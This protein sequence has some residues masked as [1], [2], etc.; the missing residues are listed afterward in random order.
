MMD[1]PNH[2]NGMFSFR[3]NLRMRMLF[4][5]P[6]AFSTVPAGFSHPLHEMQPSPPCISANSFS[7]SGNNTYRNNRTGEVT[8]GSTA[9]RSTMLPHSSWDAAA[10]LNPKSFNAV[11]TQRSASPAQ[12]SSNG[13]RPHA[14]NQP[15]LQFQFSNASD[16]S[17][18]YSQPSLSS[19]AL[20]A[21]DS[22]SNQTQNGMTSMIERMN[23]LQDRSSVPMAKRRKIQ[24]DMDD[25]T[26]NNGFSGGSSG[27][28]SG[29]VQQKQR[30]KQS[31][32]NVSQSQ[33]TLDLTGGICL[34]PFPQ[35]D[36][37]VELT[38]AQ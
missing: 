2:R 37:K 29:Y 22:F 8:N 35:L 12:L 3:Q 32:P 33:S 19:T 17:S 20:E 9:G 25:Q 1:L 36:K 38:F 4:L 15:Q 10:L 34:C 21:A 16:S 11:S 27:M 24:E 6:L 13:I 26:R 18:G 5:P 14:H 23:N 30:E 28:L 7:S 31:N